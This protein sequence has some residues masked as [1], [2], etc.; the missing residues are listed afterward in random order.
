MV[1]RFI[2][3]L[4]L[5]VLAFS[6]SV[7][8]AEP[9]VIRGTPKLTF[10]GTTATCSV[11]C[12]SGNSSDKIS[13]TLTLYQGNTYVDSWSES[14]SGRVIISERCTVKKGKDYK[15]VLSYS[16]NGQAQNSVTV[17]GTCL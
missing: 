7:H 11:D 1:K 15:L 16:V 9:R 2:S 4:V 17:T 10:N 14:G 12:K 3:I 6:I 5:L 8:A 13:A